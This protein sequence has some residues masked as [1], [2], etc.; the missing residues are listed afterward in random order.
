MTD[1]GSQA[2]AIALT[3]CGEEL[4]RALI[5]K[6]GMNRVYALHNDRREWRG[7]ALMNDLTFA[8]V[9]LNFF[10][11]HLYSDSDPYLYAH[12]ADIWNTSVDEMFNKCSVAKHAALYFPSVPF[13]QRNVPAL[14]Q[15]M[16]A[17]WWQNS[18]GGPKLELTRDRIEMSLGGHV[19]GLDQR[20][21]FFHQDRRR[22]PRASAVSP[23]EVLATP[24]CRAR[25]ASSNTT[26]VFR[27]LCHAIP[28]KVAELDVIFST[29]VM[30]GP[31]FQQYLT[32][33]FD[34]QAVPPGTI[35]P[36][37]VW[38]EARRIISTAQ[39]NPCRQL[40]DLLRNRLTYATFTARFGVLA[41][42][43]GKSYSQMLR[44]RH[45]RAVDDLEGVRVHA[46]IIEIVGD[47]ATAVN[48]LLN[49]QN[50]MGH[51]A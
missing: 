8:D 11:Q 17:L 51:Q 22:L 19:L 49:L 29:A 36:E 15:L 44:N 10:P 31:E 13:D 32:E 21:V 18:W 47:P 23:R 30:A 39:L 46:S 4:H 9:D 6:T 27:H 1:S 28:D 5:N 35:E 3:T 43:D 41:V 50:L 14:I 34:I 37:T 25:K 20:T 16:V 40:W 45:T 12:C 7:P 24:L 2:L 26:A 38:I 42:V 33:P 48:N